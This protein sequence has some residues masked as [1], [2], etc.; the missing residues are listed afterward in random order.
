M[1]CIT[2]MKKYLFSTLVTFLSI[3]L[4][5]LLTTTLYYFNVISPTTY[6][7]LKIITLLLSFFINS[8]ILGQK[9][10]KKGY[11]E[12]IK[13]SL[14]IILLFLITTIITKNFSLKILL[15]YLIII[16]TSSFGSMVGINKKKNCN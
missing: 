1:R 3:L 14:P 7:I 16:L 8:F 11:L 10:L 2:N 4:T 9:A 6:N 15:Y 12:G 5:L 13:L